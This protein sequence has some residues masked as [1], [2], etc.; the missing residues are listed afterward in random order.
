MTK[1]GLDSISFGPTAILAV[2]ARQRAV[3]GRRGPRRLPARNELSLL[4]PPFGFEPATDFLMS[5]Q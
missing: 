4:S 2:P 5:L 3:G 1:F